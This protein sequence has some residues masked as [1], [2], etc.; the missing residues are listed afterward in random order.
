V[1][2]SRVTAPSGLLTIGEALVVFATPGVGRWRHVTSASVGVAGAESNVAITVARLGEQAT[3]AGRV[4]GGGLAERIVGDLRGE[5]V[6]VVSVPD[7]GAVSLLI[8][9]RRMPDMIDVAYYRAEGPGSRLRP[10]DLE[11]IPIAGAQVLHL[12]GITA[13]L[14][15]SARETLF[16]AVRIAREAGVTVSFDVNY[17]AKLWDKSS[18]RPV[19]RDLAAQ[20]DIL[21]V[22]DDEIDLVV[23]DPADEM[24]AAVALAERGP[25]QVVV[26]RGARGAMVLHEGDV[27]KQSAFRV[28]VVDPVGAGD[29]FAGG[30]LAETLRGAP[31][32]Q[33]LRTGAACGAFAVGSAGD[34]EGNP[35]PDDLSRIAS[36]GTLR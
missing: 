32:S 31:L 2:E 16:A 28:E 29:A 14:S 15:S 22:G 33:R 8:K 7:P 24:A 34:W 17:R 6:E 4:G 20:A 18:A 11:L 1:S 36:P 10:D 26:K 9:E 13:A 30:Y 21:F 12:T 25:S 27:V 23:D 19:L 3:W 5:G 35:T